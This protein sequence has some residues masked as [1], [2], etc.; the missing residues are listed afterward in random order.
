MA[1]M[2]GLKTHDGKRIVI[3]RLA[4]DANYNKYSPGCALMNETIQYLSKETDVKVLDMSRG[5]ERYKKDFG[6]RS[7]FIKDFVIEKA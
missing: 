1:Y 2:S 3:P 5:D 7:Y 4:M 6:G